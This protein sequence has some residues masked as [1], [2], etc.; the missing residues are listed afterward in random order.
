MSVVNQL[1]LALNLSQL[2]ND[3]Q[4]TSTLKSP[5]NLFYLPLG[6][7]GLVSVFFP[8][9]QKFY[10]TIIHV[11]LFFNGKCKKKILCSHAGKIPLVNNPPVIPLLVSQRNNISACNNRLKIF[12]SGMQEM[13]THLLYAHI[14]IKAEQ[15]S[16]ELLITNVRKSLNIKYCRYRYFQK[17]KD[18]K[19]RYWAFCVIVKKFLYWWLC[20]SEKCQYIRQF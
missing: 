10:I 19:S 8:I 18:L 6:L 3:S 9:C 2:R 1:I 4:C 14:Y 12:A 17:P 13:N 20:Y 5:V 16:E 15:C 11:Q 7:K